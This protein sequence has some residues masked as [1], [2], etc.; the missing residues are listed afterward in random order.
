[1]AFR[2]K[3]VLRLLIRGVPKM[4]I[5]KH[6]GVTMKTIYDDA[7]HLTAEMREE[8]RNFD[9]PGYIGMS[10]AFYEE[11]RNVALRLATD[12]NERSNGVKMQALRAAVAAE[13]SKHNFLARIG[14][15][16][17]TP[18]TDPFNSIQTGR[19]GAYSDENDIHKFLRLF[20]SPVASQG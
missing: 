15:H 5:A 6:L 17:V 10:L 2:R 19:H 13:D 18:P 3:Q 7:W 20:E 9:Y 4:T 11:A 14:L 16:K 12:T 8:L 1:V